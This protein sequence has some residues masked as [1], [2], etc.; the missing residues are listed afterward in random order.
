MSVDFFG[1]MMLGEVDISSVAELG[2]I[3]RA[4]RK[5]S[6]LTQRDTAGAS[7]SRAASCSVREAY[8]GRAIASS[9]HNPEQLRAKVIV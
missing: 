6:G 1:L 2:K 7:M 4:V 5:E 9:L 8:S 3:I